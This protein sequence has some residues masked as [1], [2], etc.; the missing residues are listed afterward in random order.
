MRKSSTRKIIIALL[1]LL[2]ICLYFISGTYARYTWKGEATST[3]TVAKWQ[4]G[5]GEGQ[6]QTI[7]APIAL[8]VADN[9]DVVDGKIAPSYKA[10]GE[11][12]I[13][14]EGSEVAID[15]TV[16]IDVSEIRDADNGIAL[17]ITDILINGTSVK[18]DIV[19]T[20]G[21][22]SYDGTIA[23]TDQTKA[24]TRADNK[25]MVTFEATWEDDGETMDA[26]ENAGYGENQDTQAGIKTGA[27][28]T[29][30]LPVTVLMQ[31]HIEE[32]AA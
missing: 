17:N 29:L 15:Y 3:V 27:D 22:F 1:M 2:T 4:V 5:L 26:L 23:L 13:N 12:E 25:V 6:T 30:T 32:A 10:T 21:V 11:I 14:P 9:N 19:D 18:A 20:D 31:Q 8:T 7:E 16:K 24:L 28:L